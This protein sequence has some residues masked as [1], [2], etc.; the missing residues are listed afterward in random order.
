MKNF[1]PCKILRKFDSG[2]SYE[3]E[4]PVD[5]DISL[6]FNVVDLYEIIESD[7][8]IVVPNDYPKK[9]IEEV[10]QILNQR[11]GKSTRGKDYYEYL[12]KW[13]NRPVEDA[14]WIYQPELDLAQV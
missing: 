11:I 12:V 14:K 7:D 6:I 13:N 8:E 1:G 10:E 2:N 4:L 5:M 3:V 9:K